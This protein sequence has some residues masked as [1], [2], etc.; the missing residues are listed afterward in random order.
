MAADIDFS[1]LQMHKAKI[2]LY[3]RP[4]KDITLSQLEQGSV[5]QMVL[6]RVTQKIDRHEEGIGILNPLSDAF[7]L[8]NLNEFYKVSKEIREIEEH[9][10]G[11]QDYKNIILQIKRNSLVI[12]TQNI[13]KFF[14][15]FKIEL[16]DLRKKNVKA[17]LWPICYMYHWTLCVF[18]LGGSEQEDI[19]LHLDSLPGPISKH[20]MFIKL[21]TSRMYKDNDTRVYSHC[22]GIQ[23]EKGGC[24]YWVLTFI[25][26]IYMLIK[27]SPLDISSPDYIWE[28]IK[29]KLGVDLSMGHELLREEIFQNLRIIQEKKALTIK[30]L[31]KN[32]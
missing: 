29:H 23:T 8:T 3:T 17:F 21:I 2:I 11:R 27:N 26:V 22:L 7:F 30:N 9:H 12:I 10:H 31:F 20:Y 1:K 14:R 25:D 5:N 18:I 15:T 28:E 4:I 24:G 32:M 13:M 16:D 19:I 6:W